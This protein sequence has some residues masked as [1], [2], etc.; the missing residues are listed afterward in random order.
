MHIIPDDEPEPATYSKVLQ[1]ASLTSQ[2]MQPAY[3]ERPGHC[4][5]H[6][7]TECQT[8]TGNVGSDQT[9]RFIVPLH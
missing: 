1:T 7:Y 9:G 4:T 6:V 5:H 2:P 3:Q 8:M